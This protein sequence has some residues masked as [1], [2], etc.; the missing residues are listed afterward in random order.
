LPLPDES[1]LSLPIRALQPDISRPAPLS[2][3]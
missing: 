2:I 1:A 3:K